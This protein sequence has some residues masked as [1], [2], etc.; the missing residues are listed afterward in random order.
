MLDLY[1]GRTASWPRSE[2]CLPLGRPARFGNGQWMTVA[3]L[4][5]YRGAG[6][7]GRLDLDRMVRVLRQAEAVVD[8]AAGLAGEPQGAA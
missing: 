3:V 4:D 6:P 1:G 8:A 2:R 5:D 7:D